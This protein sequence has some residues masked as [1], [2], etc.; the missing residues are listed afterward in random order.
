MATQS[1][2]I[3]LTLPL[4]QANL[5]LSLLATHPFNQ[6]ASLIQ[7]IQRQA[8]SQTQNQT[9]QTGAPMPERGNGADRPT[10]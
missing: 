2:S 1:P 10:A 3:S 8:E 5:M 7:E 4:D 6:V 9:P